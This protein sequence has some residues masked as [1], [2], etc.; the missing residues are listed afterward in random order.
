MFRNIHNL[1]HVSS[2]TGPS[3]ESAHLYNTY[4]TPYYTLQYV[5]VGG[6]AIYDFI[7][8]DYEQGIKMREEPVCVCVCVCTR[9]MTTFVAFA[10]L[11]LGY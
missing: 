7:L 6:A 5:R 3:P 2:L 11:L 1:L 9:I 10:A 8:L 4:V